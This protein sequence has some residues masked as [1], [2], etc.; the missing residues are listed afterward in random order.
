MVTFERGQRSIAEKLLYLIR[1]H[2]YPVELAA[3]YSLAQV[4]DIFTGF[5][6]QPI[7]L[8]S[9]FFGSQKKHLGIP[10]VCPVPGLY[11]IYRP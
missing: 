1:T 2:F 6:F 8:Q 9:A 7:T 4:N 5:R 3:N 11:G 10:K